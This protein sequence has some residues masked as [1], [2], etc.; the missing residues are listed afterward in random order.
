[1]KINTAGTCVAAVM[2]C[3]LL[4]GCAADEPATWEEVSAATVQADATP[5]VPRQITLTATEMVER[6]NQD[7]RLVLGM[8]TIKA[9]RQV[10]MSTKD[11]ADGQQHTFTGVPITDVLD[12]IRTSPDAK[13]AEFV[14]LDDYKVS[15]PIAELRSS[16]AILAVTRDGQELPVDAGGPIRLAFP[17]GSTLGANL[18]NWIWSIASV[19]VS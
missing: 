4:A 18:D 10:K 12:Y 13:T 3:A 5:P 14:A 1:M 11:G 16:K 19:E 15:F 17:D 8:D 7:D 6:R 9:L 2:V